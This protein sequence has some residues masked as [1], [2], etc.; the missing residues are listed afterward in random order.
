M[1]FASD[2]H[3]GVLGARPHSKLVHLGL[4]D[5]DRSLTANALNRSRIVWRYEIRKKPRAAR[6]QLA[7]NRDVVFDGNGKA[8]QRAQGLTSPSPAVDIPGFL[9]KHF[10]LANRDIGF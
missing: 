10:F 4:P 7:S 8:C 6:Q 1:W 3:G 5:K 9:Q 2:V